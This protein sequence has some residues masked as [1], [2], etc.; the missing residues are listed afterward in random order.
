MSAF[1]GTL[2]LLL[3]SYRIVQSHALAGV[4]A[5]WENRGDKQR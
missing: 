4:D 3:V 5:E 2:K 1:E